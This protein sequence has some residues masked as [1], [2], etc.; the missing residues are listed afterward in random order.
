MMQFTLLISTLDPRRETGESAPRVGAGHLGLRKLRADFAR[1]NLARNTSHLAPSAMCDRAWRQGLAGSNFL[2]FEMRTDSRST[3]VTSPFA[4]RP[5]H[6]NLYGR[7]ERFGRFLRGGVVYTGNSLLT[8][9]WL[10]AHGSLR[11][12]GP[13]VLAT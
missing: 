2:M 11:T 9:A 12:V 6:S 10:I 8:N 4:T 5:H 7:I 13:W 1:S 3:S